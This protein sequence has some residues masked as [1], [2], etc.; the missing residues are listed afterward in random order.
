VPVDPIKCVAG[1]GCLLQVLLEMIDAHEQ[2][3]AV[4]CHELAHFSPSCARLYEQLVKYPQEIIPLMDMVM[5]EEL[6]TLLM[7]QPTSEQDASAQQSLQVQVRVFNLA[8]TTSLR[9]LEP[10]HIDTLV[11]VR[12][13]VIRTSAVIPDM[14][15]A[16]FRC[17][18]R[19]CGHTLQVE[20][21]RG[22]VDVPPV[23][24]VCSAK[25]SL[26]IV[27]NR[28]T[29]ND[30][31]LIKVQETPESIPQGET[32][33]T[34]S[35]YA[36]EDLVDSV[37]PG[38]RVQ[39][40]G[41]F[42]ALPQR[43]NPRMRTLRSVFRSFVDI[44]HVQKTQKGRLSAEDPSVTEGEF[45]SMLGADTGGL[46]AAI[47]A[48]R[49][50]VIAMSEEASLYERLS[51]SLAPSIWEL[52]DVKKGLLLQLFGGTNKDMGPYGK[53]RGEIN[54]LLCGDPGTSKSQLLGYV[55][56]IAPRGIYTSGK[57]SSAV[58]LTAYVT[59][60]P[61]TKE[62][63]LE[64]GALVLSDRG[65]CCIDEFDKMSD[66]TRSIL[67]EVMEQQTVSVAKAGII[68]TLNA[69]TSVLASAN[70]VE[71]RY[72]PRLSV[73]ENIQLPPTLLSR[74]DLIYL[75]LDRCDRDSDRR[76]ANHIVSLYFGDDQRNGAMSAP[77]S[78]AQLTEYISYARALIHPE[79]TDDAK[80]L[81]IKGYTDM[82]RV[83]SLGGGRKVITATPRQLESLIRLSEAHARMRL[84]DQVLPEDVRE[85]IRLVN[86]ATQ[87]AATDPS[88]GTIDL[89][90]I[91]T[92]KT[93]LAR[94]AVSHIK[95]ALEAWLRE[96]GHSGG[97]RVSR[98]HWLVRERRRRGCCC[99][100]GHDWT[101]GKGAGRA[102]RGADRASGPPQGPRDAR[103]RW[104]HLHGPRAAHHHHRLSHLRVCV[105]VCAG[106]NA[107]SVK[108]I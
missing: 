65:I 24:P 3:V 35:L 16:F 69:R 62:P 13:M 76:L 105:C 54:V 39:I 6:S 79:L 53:S 45:R 103:R 64:S 29:F 104:G 108:S 34:I 94:D 19:N 21:D 95:D 52:D 91:H 97:S 70:P 89:D 27:H 48:R 18:A 56:K 22:R 50:R 99:F 10:R 44:I 25:G 107:F 93:A 101:G 51:T 38:D 100:A 83:G 12:G 71:S 85:A 66:S 86:V 8:T 81:L 33:H 74:F 41:I 67:H 26:G 23:C 63:V 30:K 1:D 47:E 42:R 92:G 80:D 17:S 11:S 49:E 55:N 75:V 82:R 77:F 68:C 36:H 84:R 28:C 106:F 57:G 73:V 60:D 14:R 78:K 31:Q 7:S 43:V 15:I 90:M 96:G 46:D 72:N 102:E 58:G 59:K 40:T 9:L 4:D 37:V 87:R 98:L 32:P 5:T 2:H 61:D 88:T 20:N